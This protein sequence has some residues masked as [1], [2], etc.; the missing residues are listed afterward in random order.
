MGRV[1]SSIGLWTS[2]SS[3]SRLDGFELSDGVEGGGVAFRISRKV[4][5]FVRGAGEA[6]ISFCRSR[7]L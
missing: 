1:G 5:S 7:V 4:P 6:V 3:V 2:V